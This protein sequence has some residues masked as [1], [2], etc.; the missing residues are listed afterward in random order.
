[1]LIQIIWRKNS[2]DFCSNDCVDCVYATV[3]HF[4]ETLNVR[5]VLDQGTAD[6]VK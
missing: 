4:K 3:A 2:L 6:A 1:M 5:S